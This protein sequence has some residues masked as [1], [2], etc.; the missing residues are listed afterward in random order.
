MIWHYNGIGLQSVGQPSINSAIKE[1]PS[2]YGGPQHINTPP[3][4][5]RPSKAKQLESKSAA[6]SKAKFFL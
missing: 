6:N 2:T 5:D 1:Q 4:L 3:R